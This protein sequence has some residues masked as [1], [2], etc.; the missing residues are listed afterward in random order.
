MTSSVEADSGTEPEGDPV[1][2]WVMVGVCFVLGGL[3]FGVL[4]SVGVF[5]KPLVAEFGWS[6]GQTAFG[7]SMLSFASAIMGVA[8]G[9]VADRYGSERLIM[10]GAFSMV[11]A[12]LGLSHLSQLWHFY[13]AYFL[14]GAVGFSTFMGPLFGN[15]GHWFKHNPGLA[16]GIAAA[17]GA[18]GQAVIPFIVRL[19]ISEY[20][21]RTAYFVLAVAYLIIAVPLALAVKDPP[22]RKAVQTNVRVQTDPRYSL[23]PIEIMTWVC[24]AVIFCCIT[25]SMPI[26][27]L[28]PLISD[29]GIAPE[30]AASVLL[31]LMLSGAAGRIAGGKFADLLGPLPTFMLASAGQTIL[32]IWFP[33]I[34]SMIG[35]YILAVAFG[36]AY[37]ADMV[38]IIT[39][40]RLMIPVHLAGR[41]IGLGTAFGM[42]GMGLGGY[43]GGALY[44]LHGDYVW[45]FAAAAL[46]GGINLLILSGLV[47][48]LGMARRNA[49][50]PENPRNASI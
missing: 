26:V 34:D 23:P 5:L 47:L 9:Y 4:G 43:L 18:L 30:T 2:G 35:I 33:H 20:D 32:V 36:F 45:A 48:R 19:M 17:G 13:A 8:W 14:F 38:S 16:L 24:A 27:H 3:A 40:M 25:M 1:Q 7:Y 28:V 37:S 42:V 46:S 41:A 29:R 22:S 12:L 39:C 50:L 11:V 15:V 6:R 44:D 10:A 49:L 31:V 21:W